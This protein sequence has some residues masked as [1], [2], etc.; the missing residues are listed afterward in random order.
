[1]YFFIMNYVYGAHMSI[2]NGFIAAMREAHDELGTNGM[3][4]F[5]KS[6]R[7]RAETKLTS[8]SAREFKQYSQ[9]IG[10][11]FIVAHCSYLLNF[12]KP[13]VPWALSSLIDD[14]RGVEMLGGVGVV[15]HVGKSLELPYGSAFDFLIKNLEDVLSATSGLKA[16]II[17]ENT[18]G[19]GTEMG[20][21]FEELKDI[22][23]A[24]GKNKRV[25]FCLDTCHAWAWGY[26][27]TNPSSVF[28]EFDKILGLK[29]LELIHF[30]DAM[31]VRGSRVDR[32]ANLGQGEIG[33]AS[34]KTIIKFAGKESIPMIVETPDVIHGVKYI[35]RNM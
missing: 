3:Q 4:I 11:K 24:L 12:A 20:R 1:M 33:E 35:Q 30:N 34:L 8:D 28:K 22:Y 18:A 21:S 15:L 10:F 17:L 25:S 16:K 31:K 19:Q 9:D 26:D 13:G 29:N 7:G 2:A 6:P 32:H 14:L 27:F 23:D 5:M